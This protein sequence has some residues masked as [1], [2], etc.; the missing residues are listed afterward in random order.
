MIIENLKSWRDYFMNFNK[1]LMVANENF[2]SKNVLDNYEKLPNGLIRQKR[3]ISKIKYNRDYIRERYDSYKSASVNM[4]FLRLGYLLGTLKSTPSSILDVGYGNGDFLSTANKHIGNFG[5]CYGFEVNGYDIP[6]GC[7]KVD[8][9]FSNSYDVVCFFDVLEHFDN[10]Y[11]I[12]NLKTNYIYISVP[13]CTYL[14]DE[15]FL[16]WKHRRPDEHLWHFNENSLTNFMSEMGFIKVSCC[17]IED[18]LRKSKD[19]ENI[20]TSIFKK[21]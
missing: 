11:D 16:N 12:Q 8:D 14:S 9:I 1:K 2:C 17:F 7:I 10:V 21:K 6:D 20:L 5:K 3:I 13:N 19:S 4:G 15:W 18:T